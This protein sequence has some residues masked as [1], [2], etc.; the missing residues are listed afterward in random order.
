MKNY[1]KA[2]SRDMVNPE[3]N[4]G[5]ELTDIEVIKGETDI[6]RSLVSVVLGLDR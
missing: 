5:F 1:D 4:F 2:M 6:E 3:Y